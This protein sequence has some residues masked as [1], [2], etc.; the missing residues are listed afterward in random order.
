MPPISLCNV[1]M[2]LNFLIVFMCFLQH[3]TLR[4]VSIFRSSAAAALVPDQVGKPFDTGALRN[5]I[6]VKKPG[7]RRP[8]DRAAAG[9][10]RERAGRRGQRTEWTGARRVLSP[11]AAA[12]ASTAPV[13]TEHVPPV[14]KGI[15]SD[16]GRMTALHQNL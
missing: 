10:R 1:T 8:A 16:V 15:S 11:S 6:P 3:I 7:G 12:A 5:S 2:N 14:P 9:E 4:A 13:S